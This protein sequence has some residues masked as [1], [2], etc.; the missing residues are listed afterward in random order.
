MMMLTVHMMMV[1]I[2]FVDAQMAQPQPWLSRVC[3]TF[4]LWAPRA[5]GSGL[6]CSGYGVDRFSILGSESSVAILVSV[7]GRTDSGPDVP[8]KEVT[9]TECALTTAHGNGGAYISMG[10]AK[11]LD[12]GYE[13]QA[14]PELPPSSRMEHRGTIARRGSEKRAHR[15]AGNRALCD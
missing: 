13:V 7:S 2:A 8:P 12:G 9:L 4:K 14:S 5:R 15:N 1:T 10:H 11:S 3:Q 6:G